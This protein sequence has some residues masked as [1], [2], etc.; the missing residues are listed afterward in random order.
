MPRTSLP[1]HIA[2]AMA[3]ST[4]RKRS[5]GRLGGQRKKNAPRC[6]CEAMTL[7]RALARGKSAEHK[8]DCSFYREM[9]IVADRQGCIIINDGT[10]TTSHD[11]TGLPKR[12]NLNSF[13]KRLVKNG[14]Q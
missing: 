2:R 6:P 1:S 13:G 11:K 12:T 9:A 14:Q 8:P 7:K 10:P 3:N 4:N 5:G